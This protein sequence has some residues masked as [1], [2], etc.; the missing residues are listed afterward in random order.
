MRPARCLYT[1]THQQLVF[2]HHLDIADK[3]RKHATD[4]VVAAQL[5]VVDA[6]CDAVDQLH[7]G[8][9]RD[10]TCDCK[11]GVSVVHSLRTAAET[12]PW[13]HREKKTWRLLP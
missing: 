11:G 2:L 10:D 6:A 1:T 8:G 9:C 7:R 4:D 3:Q 5:A 12:Y 13:A